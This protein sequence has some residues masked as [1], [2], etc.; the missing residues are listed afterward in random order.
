MDAISIAPLI[1]WGILSAYFLVLGVLSVYG[2]HRWYLLHLYRRNR[3]R[4]PRPPRHYEEL[5]VLTVQLPLYNEIYVVERLV[6]EQAVVVDGRVLTSRGAGTA[7]EFGLALV[8]AMVGQ[9]QADAV[10]ASIHF[11]EGR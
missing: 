7:V 8:A 1:R 6:G 10:A 2:V 3:N 11:T 5:P 9:E 4:A